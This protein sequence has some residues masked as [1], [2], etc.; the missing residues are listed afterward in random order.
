VALVLVLVKVKA[1]PGTPEPLVSLT[2]PEISPKVW[3]DNGRTNAN[4]ANTDKID[5]ILELTLFWNSPTVGREAI[6][7][8]GQ[9]QGCAKLAV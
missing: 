6:T 5:R 8:I 3:P 4:V 2:L 7:R 1:A 9:T